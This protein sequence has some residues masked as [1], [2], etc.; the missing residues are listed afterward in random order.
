MTAVTAEPDDDDFEVKLKQEKEKKKEDALPVTAGSD[1]LEQESLSKD[2]DI[3][4]LVRLKED[5]AVGQVEGST[6]WIELE[7]KGSN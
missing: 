2:Q 6:A 4:L 5:Q 7:S 1:D 3:K